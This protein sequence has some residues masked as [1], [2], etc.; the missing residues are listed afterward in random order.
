MLSKE[1]KIAKSRAHPGCARLTSSAGVS[2][3]HP[4]LTKQAGQFWMPIVGQLCVLIDRLLQELVAEQIE[5][6][7]TAGM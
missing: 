7:A 5:R 4:C 6:A 3:D 2:A 1:S